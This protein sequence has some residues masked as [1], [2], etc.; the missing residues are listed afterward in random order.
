MNK[1]GIVAPGKAIVVGN[2]PKGI[3]VSDLNL[4]GKADIVVCNQLDNSITIIISK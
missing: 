3:A 1:N 4:D 2:H